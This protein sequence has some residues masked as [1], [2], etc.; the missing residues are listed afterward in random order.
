[1]KTKKLRLDKINVVRLNA[2]HAILGGRKGEPTGVDVPHSTHCPDPPQPS[3]NCYFGGEQSISTKRTMRTS[4][5]E[6]V[7]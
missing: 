5:L 3:S 1:M 4:S 7:G 2:T 6:C